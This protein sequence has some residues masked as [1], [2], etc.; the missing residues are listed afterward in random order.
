MYLCRIYEENLTGDA[1]CLFGFYFGAVYLGRPGDRE[2]LHLKEGVGPL[3]EV[4]LVLATKDPVRQLDLDLGVM[5]LLDC[6]LAALGGLD[7]L[8]LH[9]LD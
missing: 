7:L 8:H 1:L 2:G 9:D 4:L 6:W 5:E 3:G